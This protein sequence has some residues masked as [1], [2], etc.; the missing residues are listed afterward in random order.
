[1]SAAEVGRH[2]AGLV[3]IAVAA[4]LVPWA[5]MRMLRPSLAASGRTVCNYRGVRVPLGLGIVWALW[6]AGV[7]LHQVV[8]IALSLPH[9]CVASL[10]FEVTI[11][12][13]L[14]FGAFTFGLIDDSFGTAEHK[15]FRGHLS[16]LRHGQLTTGGLKLF[17][18]GLLALAG[19][20]LPAFGLEGLSYRSVVHYAVSVL[21]IGLASNTVNLFDLRPTRALKVYSLLAVLA[22]GVGVAG[23]MGRELV[24]SRAVYD[25]LLVLILALGPVCAVW[26]DDASERG[27]LGDAGANAFGMLAGLLLASALPLGGAIVVAALLLG[28]NLA[29]EK[30]SFSA[31]IERTPWLAA[32][33]RWGRPALGAG[34]AG[35]RR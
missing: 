12:V 35:D 28:L 9:E 32:I 4:A 27:V 33:D 5:G 15:G 10:W 22:V 1:M 13:P 19:A 29:S 26:G 8:A 24:T 7:A 14:V 6:A 20:A 34:E 30:V 3:A 21:L 17:G 23:V 25:G 18:I 16:A 2:A 31:V 11:A